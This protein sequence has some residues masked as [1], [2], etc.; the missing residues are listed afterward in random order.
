VTIVFIPR[1]LHGV[2]TDKQVR[3]LQQ[4]NVHRVL[5]LIAAVGERYACH[6]V[7]HVPRITS[8]G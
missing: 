7:N 3:E 2:I 6:R 4:R 5:G 1:P 8:K